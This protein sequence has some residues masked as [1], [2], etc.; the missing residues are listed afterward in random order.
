[1]APAHATLSTP[2]VPSKWNSPSTLA[3]GAKLLKDRCSRSRDPPLLPA[4]HK[5][6]AITFGVIE[7]RPPAK[8][9]LDRRLRE[10]DAT[11]RKRGVG[12]WQVVTA[13]HDVRCGQHV[14]NGSTTARPGR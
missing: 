13:E 9:L 12:R 2:Q 1:M 5:R 7:E 8:R 6:E 14:G 10:L 11:R 4:G 3:S